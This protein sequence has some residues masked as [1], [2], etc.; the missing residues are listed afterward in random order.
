M[1]DAD[2]K[3]IPHAVSKRKDAWWYEEDF[4][5]SVVV[6]PQEATTTVAIHWSDLR[7]ALARKDKP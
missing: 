5:I 6:E 1:S 2:L 3:R 7:R 4:G